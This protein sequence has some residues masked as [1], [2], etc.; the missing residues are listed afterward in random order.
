MAQWVSVFTVRQV[1]EFI[2]KSATSFPKPTR[3]YLKMSLVWR[4]PG[5]SNSVREGHA[6]QECRQWLLL[7]IPCYKSACRAMEW[8]PR[9]RGDLQLTAP[10][11]LASAG[12]LETQICWCY[13]YCWYL[14]F[15][16]EGRHSA[17][18]LS[19]WGTPAHAHFPQTVSP[20][21]W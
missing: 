11:S 7:F 6:A 3:V 9:V 4:C 20:G 14:F 13:L 1:Y 21:H 12:C 16:L 5:P 18:I 8:R 2:E 19:K 17:W 10:A 15:R